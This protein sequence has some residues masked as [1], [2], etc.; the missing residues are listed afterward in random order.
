MKPVVITKPNELFALCEKVRKQNRRVGFVPTMGALHDGHLSL[1]DAASAY[2]DFIVVSIF[3]NPTQFGPNEDYEKYPR[4]LD[5]DLLKLKEKVDAVYAPS[6]QDMYPKG[7]STSIS[8]SGLTSGL[9]GANRPGHFDGVALVVTKLLCAVGPC[10]AVFG[11]KDYQQLQ[12]IKRMVQDL[13][14]PVTIIEAKT[15]RDIDGL[16]MS[17]RNAYLSTE[18]RKRALSIPKALSKAHKLFAETDITAGLV[19]YEVKSQ[20]EKEADEVHYIIAADP[21][22]LSP[23][24]ENAQCKKLLIAIAAKFGSTRLIDNI[25]LGEDNCPCVCTF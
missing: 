18:E 25:V 20:I 24:P 5:S 19:L 15:H 23:V 17:S 9:C 13:N 8:V 2:S 3:V 12:V 6:A 4:T 14:L 16:A 7:F 22:T 21:D 11:R 1:V 10:S